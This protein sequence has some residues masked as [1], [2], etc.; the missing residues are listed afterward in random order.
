MYCCALSSAPN[1]YTGGNF[2]VL[3]PAGSAKVTLDVDTLTDNIL[4]DAEFFK[5]TLT[6][7][8]APDNVVVGSPNMAFV[9]IADGTSTYV[10]ISV[11]YKLL[12]TPLR[13]QHNMLCKPLLGCIYSSLLHSHDSSEV[14]PIQL[15][16]EGRSGQ[17][18]CHHLGST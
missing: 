16:C 4:E 11:S 15:H 14:Q 7:P 8:D 12:H 2:S 1:D 9:T 6:I 17:Q 5:A 13:L 10:E 3:V 18:C